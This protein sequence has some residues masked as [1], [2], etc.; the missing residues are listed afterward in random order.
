[1]RATFAVVVDSEREV[2]A[3]FARARGFER[4]VPAPFKRAAHRASHAG[5]RV[6][7]GVDSSRRVPRVQPRMA[8]SV[9]SL[10]AERCP[11]SWPRTVSG[12]GSVVMTAP[13]EAPIQPVVFKT[14][15]PI[16]FTDID[17]Y[18]HVATA[19]YV[20]YV[21]THR[22]DFIRARFGVGQE[23]FAQRG[24]GFVVRRM[25]MDFFRPIPASQTDVVV[26]S[27]VSTLDGGR[28]VVDYKMEHPS[29]APPPLE[30][31]VRLSHHRPPKGRP[32]RG[33]RLDARVVHR[34]AV[35]P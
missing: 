26:E 11:L 14:T 10:S 13:G 19:H 18:G 23:V 30:W 20:E 3:T 22:L 4:E 12:G 31:P 17:R 33:P 35:I 7:G 1:L 29:G 2:H 9:L 28:F 5:A 8:L 21:Y 32:V 27:F 34:G 6:A 25:E 15:V 16:R 24:V